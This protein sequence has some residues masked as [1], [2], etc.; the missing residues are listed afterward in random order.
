MTPETT[1]PKMSKALNA[2][3]NHL[4]FNLCEWGLDNPWEWADAIAQSW[5]ATGDHTGIWASTKEIVASVAKIPS[6]YTGRPYG[7]NDMDMLEVCACRATEGR[8]G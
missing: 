4:S 6:E 3:G 1:Y 8:R 2:S 5:R 7:W